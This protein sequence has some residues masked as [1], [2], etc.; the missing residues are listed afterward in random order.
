LPVAGRLR[1]E[2]HHQKKAI[3]QGN[4][5]CRSIRMDCFGLFTFDRRKKFAWERVDEWIAL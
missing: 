2:D 3:E 5:K 1:A 4:D